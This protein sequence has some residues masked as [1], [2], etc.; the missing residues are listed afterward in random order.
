MG[1]DLDYIECSDCGT[2]LHESRLVYKEVGTGYTD[3]CPV[4][5]RVIEA[6]GKHFEH[7]FSYDEAEKIR[8]N[9]SRFK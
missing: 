9:N 7:R 1:R 8:Q 2:I 5:S 6:N 4:C 3:S